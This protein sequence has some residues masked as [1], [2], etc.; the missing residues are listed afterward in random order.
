M[1]DKE[2]LEQVS[3]DNE[4]LID[5]NRE[6]DAEL[7]R[8]KKVLG[9]CEHVA[10]TMEFIYSNVE[11][12]CNPVIACRDF[13]ACASDIKRACADTKACASDI[14]RACAD[15]YGNLLVTDNLGEWFMDGLGQVVN[16]LPNTLKLLEDK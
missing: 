7:A 8:C 1:T 13:K 15:T 11:K 2:R 3:Q 14:K 10:D 5:R 6:L 4:K 12:G 9:K 16:Q